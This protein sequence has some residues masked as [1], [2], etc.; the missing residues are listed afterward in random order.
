[1][2]LFLILSSN[3]ILIL[4]FLIFKNK[5]I[6]NKNPIVINVIIDVI[7]WLLVIIAKTTTNIKLTILKIV[8]LEL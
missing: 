7:Y 2:E 5:I 6:S 1:M 4:N 8:P 3:K